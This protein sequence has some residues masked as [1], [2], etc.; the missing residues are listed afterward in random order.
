MKTTSICL[1][2]IAMLTASCGS[3]GK[4]K[5]DNTSYTGPDIT[6]TISPKGTD[7]FKA[8][9]TSIAQSYTIPDWFRDAKFGIFIHWGVYA[10]PAFGNEWYPRKMYDKNS[11][12]Y[13]HHVETYGELTDFGYK[14]FIPMF[15]AERFDPQAWAKLFKQSGARYVIPVAEHHDGFAMYHSTFNKWNAIDMGPHRDIIGDLR[16]AILKEKL[17]FGLSSHRC[18]NAWF[19]NYGMEEPSDVQNP[20][21]TLY[22]ERLHKPD[23]KSG[24]VECDKYPG[25]NEKSRKEWL[26]ETYELIDQ[27]QPELFW[28]DWTVGN[29][30]F[31]PTFYQFMA[32][33]YNNAKDWNKGVVVNT[34]YGYGDNI[35]VYDIERGK[36]DKARQYPWQT[37]TSVGK[38]SWGYIQGE[39]NKTPNQIIDDL[40]DIVS[41]NGNLLLNIGPKA[42]GTITQGQ[43]QVLLAIGKWLQVNGEA[44][45]G[46]RPWKVTASEGATKGTAGSFTDNKETKYSA[47]DIRFTT[48]DDTLYAISLEWTDENVIIQSLKGYDIKSISMLGSNEEISYKMTKG[49]LKVYFPEK[50]PN[51]FA[52]AFRIKLQ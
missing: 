44:I 6:T 1:M 28:F 23:N 52:Y 47:Q 41:K 16:E 34:K 13:R 5:D 45:Y 4:S 24:E 17:H 11:E 12:E 46:T 38:K 19:F 8:D 22:G 14:D 29:K 35:Q 30:P 3:S 40:I 2:L 7:L 33:Y 18:E 26:T 39:E 31:Q 21:N 32:Y 10:V 51:D 15:K 9:S 36:S 27:Y 42:D 48:K 20:E 37:D 49:G 43:Q 50:R 25:S